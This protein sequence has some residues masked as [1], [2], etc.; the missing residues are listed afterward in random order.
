MPGSLGTGTFVRGK[1]IAVPKQGSPSR[2]SV[3]HPLNGAFTVAPWVPS[4]APPS[5]GRCCLSLYTLAQLGRW[6][7]VAGDVYGCQANKNQEAFI[8]S[9]HFRSPSGAL[10]PLFPNVLELD[11]SGFAWRLRALGF[12][13]C[14]LGDL[15]SRRLQVRSPTRSEDGHASGRRASHP[16]MPLTSCFRIVFRT[17]FIFTETRDSRQPHC[18]CQGVREAWGQGRADDSDDNAPSSALR[19]GENTEG[20]VTF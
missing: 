4:F 12:P 7:G 19:E 3:T 13:C 17:N 5:A 2:P 8:C 20:S 14:A 11:P 10:L 15:R 9:R 1:A 16:K 18:T 6:A